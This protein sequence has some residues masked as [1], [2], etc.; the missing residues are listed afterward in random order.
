MDQWIIDSLAALLLWGVW[1]FLGKLA[2]RSLDHRQLV[3]LSLAGYSLIFLFVAAHGWGRGVLQASP[4]GAGLALATGLFSGVAY[5]FFYLG[6]SRGEASRIVTITALYPVISVLL[7]FLIL[8][9]AVTITKILGLAM[10]IGGL[11]LLSI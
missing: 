8:R 1:G 9:E 5:F 3:F 2:S 4:K 6:I 11:I 7:A 10:A